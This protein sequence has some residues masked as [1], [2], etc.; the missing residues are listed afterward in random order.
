MKNIVGQ[1]VRGENFFKRPIVIKKIWKALESGSD[2]LISAPRRYGKTSIM[3]HLLDNPE[4]NYNLIYIIVESINNENELFGRI[5]NK[6]I[7][8]NFIDRFEGNS[9]IAIR[10]LL[11][12]IR[13]LGL[14]QEE[15]T[16]LNYRQEFIKLLGLLKNNECIVIMI[17]E[18]S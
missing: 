3:L 1:P 8:S 17:D 10:G 7:E 5:L 9:K 4:E 15:S 2:I 14:E 12:R 6:I 13:G 18:F 11:Q 16:E